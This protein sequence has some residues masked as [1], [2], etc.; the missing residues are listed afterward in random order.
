MDSQVAR[1]GRVVS[2]H[3]GG[4]WL[5]PVLFL[6]L[7]PAPMGLMYLVL[8][9]GALL[10]QGQS[11]MA[12]K[13]AAVALFVVG[14]VVVLALL[15]RRL[16]ARRRVDVHERGVVQTRL[17]HAQRIVEFANVRGVTLL[18]EGGVSPGVRIALATGGQIEL[19][20]YENAEQL[21][22]MVHRGASAATAHAT[23]GAGWRSSC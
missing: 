13:V 14:L 10:H 3:R 16:E 8:G 12:L 19:R 21:A 1:L 5:R 22:A 23:P 7:M 17:L 15:V 9:V 18:G 2:E 20:D 6:A 11:F 4:G